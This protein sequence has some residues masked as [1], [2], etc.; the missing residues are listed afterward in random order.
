MSRIALGAFQRKIIWL[1]A[2]ALTPALFAQA[3]RARGEP[4]LRGLTDFHHTEWG[5]LGAVF[6]VKQSP[7]GYLWLTT[8]KGVLR[9]DG[10]RFQTLEEV[11]RGAVHDSDIDSIFLAA[12][13]GLWLP[14]EGAG[15]LFWKDGH[16][17]NFPDRR[18]TPSRKQGQIIEDREGSLWVQ[19]TAGL[20]RLRGS[21]CEQIGSELGYPGGFP[22]AVFLDRDGTLWVKTQTGPLLSLRRDESRFETTQYGDGVST[23][24]AFLRQA[25]DG[26]I[27]LSD[28]QG[29][30]RVTS[31]SVWNRTPSKRRTPFEVVSQR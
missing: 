2:A 5:G 11:T 24:F 10:V 6:D 19:A 4:V 8:S 16:L 31:S 23:G 18:C 17:S 15:L 14:T 1:A 26:T 12:S 25:P 9:F 27:W 29:L 7:E 28:N 30:R 3:S 22:A 21:V 20:F 13:G